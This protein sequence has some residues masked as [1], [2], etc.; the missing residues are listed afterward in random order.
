MHFFSLN[1]MHVARLE[2]IGFRRAILSRKEYPKL[3]A[4]VVTVDFSGWPIFTHSNV[5][6]QI[7][8]SFCIAL[9]NR[10]DRIPWQGDGPLP[11]ERMCEDSPDGPLDVPLHPA[12]E[13]FW[14]ERGYL[15]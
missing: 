13:T 15:K 4:D 9:D 3:P 7:V 5:S 1:E 10:K 11:L 12:A 8:R 6:D 2:D 14:R